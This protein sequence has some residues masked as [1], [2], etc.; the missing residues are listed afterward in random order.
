MKTQTYQAAGPSVE[1]EFSAAAAPGEN[2]G[3][4]HA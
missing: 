4:S 2:S 3:L 1:R